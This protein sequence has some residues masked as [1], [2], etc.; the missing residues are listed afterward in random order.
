MWPFT[1]QFGQNLSEVDRIRPNL[2]CACPSFT[3]NRDEFDQH[4]LMST[5]LCRI[6]PGSGPT[7]TRFGP[8]STNKSCVSCPFSACP[9]SI[10]QTKCVCVCL[11][12]PIVAIWAQESRRRPTPFHMRHCRAMAGRRLNAIRPLRHRLHGL[13]AFGG[14]ARGHFFE[15]R[16]WGRRGRPE[17]RRHARIRT[18]IDAALR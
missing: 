11:S 7:S 14:S 2:G 6:E 18:N 9:K 1:S 4:R 12:L 16:F 17:R 5:K 8:Y 10:R 3:K 15:G 13:G